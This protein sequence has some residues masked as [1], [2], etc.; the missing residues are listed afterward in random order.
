MNDWSLF[1]VSQDVI[2]NFEIKL[3]KIET[4]EIIDKEKDCNTK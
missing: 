1:S 4:Y 2:K 3:E